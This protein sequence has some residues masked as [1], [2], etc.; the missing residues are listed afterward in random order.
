MSKILCIIDGMNDPYFN[1]LKYPALA[2]FPVRNQVE[3]VPNGFEAETLPCV[4][5]L[6]GAAPPPKNIRGWIEALGAGIEIN[7][8]DLVFRGSWVKLDDN[9]ICKEFCKAP[10]NLPK[11]ERVRYIP[12][13]GYRVYILK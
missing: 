8:E 6:L 4:L 1:V 11:I 3:T 10:I 12:L 2:S 13:G 7:S 5:S 9:G